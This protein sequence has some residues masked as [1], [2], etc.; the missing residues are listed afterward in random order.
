MYEGWPDR[1]AEMR[2][3]VGRLESLRADAPVYW[4]DEVLA[5]QTE[6]AGLIGQ[7]PVFRC[8]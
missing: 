1:F 3:I 6:V 7:P 2:K 8:N 5:L 4:I